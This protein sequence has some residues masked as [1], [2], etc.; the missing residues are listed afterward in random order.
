VRNE[1]DAFVLEAMEQRGIGPSEEADPR[2]LIRRLSLDITGLPPTRDEAAAF[3]ADRSP[4]AYSHLV[5]RLLSSSRFGEHFAATWL[6]AA[7]YADSN[8]FQHDPERTAWPWRDWVVNALNSGMPYDRFV[9]EQLA[10]D[11]IP[12]AT[13][14][15]L[16]A[17]A[18]N[19]NHPLNSE[20]GRDKE[21]SR[22]D[23]VHDRVDATS[24]V[25]LGLTMSCA[26]CHD[27]KYDPV[28]QRDYYRLFAYFNSVDEDGGADAGDV[29]PL[30]EYTDDAGRALKV[31]VMRDRAAPRDS[32]VLERGAWDHP[33]EAI[34]PG[35]PASLPRSRAQL[36]IAWGWRNGSWTAQTR[37]RHGW[38]SIACGNSS[39]GAGWFA[40]RTTS[41]SRGSAPHIRNFWIGWRNGLSNTAGIP[42]R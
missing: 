3:L 26:Q 21:E 38:R 35:T 13:R 32:H 12:G 25:F 15:Q 37:S 40:L 2:T 16:L 17:T 7:R 28:S 29:P 31:M 27:H 34:T 6:E 22:I 41:G 18:F 8:G 39:S 4:D 1:I 10:G 20:G 9:L 19:R 11:L 42:R 36:R 23:Y 14:S 30:M 33:G 24:T 5:D